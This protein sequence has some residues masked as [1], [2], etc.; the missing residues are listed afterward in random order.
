MMGE[1][2]EVG[3]GVY[4]KLKKGDRIGALHDHLR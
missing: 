1:V 2:V 3:S 4:G